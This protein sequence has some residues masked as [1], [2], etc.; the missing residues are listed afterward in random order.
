ML[1]KTAVIL[2]GLMA[3]LQGFYGLFAYIDA[4]SFAQVRGTALASLDWVTIYASRTAFI[5]LLIGYLLYLRHYRILMAAALI[6]TVMPITDGWLAYQSG[7]AA[8]VVVKH[9]ATFA[10]LCLTGGILWLCTPKEHA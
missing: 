4:S 9:V 1:N 6:G 7:A 2:V 3:V 5:A 10:Y 8:S